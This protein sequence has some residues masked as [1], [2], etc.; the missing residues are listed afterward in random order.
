M[1]FWIFSSCIHIF[2]K[3]AKSISVIFLNSYPPLEER[4]RESY[5]I[6][7][8]KK[9]YL[10]GL[11]SVECDRQ[12]L[13]EGEKPSEMEVAGLHLFK[14]FFFMCASSAVKK[15]VSE[16]FFPIKWSWMVCLFY[17]RKRKKVRFSFHFFVF[18]RILLIMLKFPSLCKNDHEFF[19]P[20][21]E[22]RRFINNVN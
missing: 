21:Q 10:R 1:I 5:K 2:N 3:K 16:F 15:R 11:F 4:E 18:L 19:S 8:K 20:H 22:R 12:Q 6:L 17:S 14:F 7:W 9:I 13:R